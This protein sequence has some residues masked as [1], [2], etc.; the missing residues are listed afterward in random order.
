MK[1]WMKFFKMFFKMKSKSDEK[2][3]SEFGKLLSEKLK[4]FLIL[5]FQ[6]IIFPPFH[7]LVQAQTL[8]HKLPVEVIDTGGTL[9]LSD[10]PEYVRRD[11]IL[12][13]DTV[14]GDARI[15]FY[16][17]NDTTERKK[18][19]VIVENVS[20]KSTTVEISRG[21]FAAPSENY[22]AV[23][24]SIQ[25]I[26]MQDNLH[27]SFKLKS[28]ERKILQ[29]EMDLT[30]I[31]PANLACGVYDFYSKQP[32]QIFVLMYPADS[33]PLNFLMT[34][35]ILPKDEHRLRG[36]F[37]RC[38]RSIKLQKIFNPADGIGYIL[39]C[40]DVN[41][42]FKKGIDATDNSE[43]VNAGNYGINYTLDFQTKKLTRFYLCPLGGIYA[44]AVKFKCN[45][46]FGVIPTPQD[47][48]FFGEKTPP[49]SESVR[50]AR[51]EGLAFFTNALEISELGNFSGRIF[52]EYSPPG[53]SNLPIQIILF[54]AE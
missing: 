23:G 32:V 38:N 49:E 42:T 9:L 3:E 33:E 10:S 44:G 26:Y 40:D 29:P 1:S 28:R 52:F 11:G 24:K 13:T 45:D 8:M 48:L 2:I 54:P 34:A 19:A 39:I 37:K 7:L 36:T 27:D 30:V 17:L 12:Y 41:D 18:I 53:A 16:H 47:K 20:D 14:S 43:V 25:E 6:L 21:A 22:F 4:I 50:I 15:F 5:T 51:E 31:N 46:G 35:D